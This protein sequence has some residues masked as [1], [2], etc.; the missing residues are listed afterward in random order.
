[1]HREAHENFADESADN[2]W[3]EVVTIHISQGVLKMP[4]SLHIDFF[5][6]VS[7]KTQVHH[8]FLHLQH[9]RHQ[10]SVDGFSNC[11]A[12]RTLNFDTPVS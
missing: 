4:S 7:L 10:L 8:S 9:I 2:V 12:V 11:V 1:M 5:A 3:N 6:I